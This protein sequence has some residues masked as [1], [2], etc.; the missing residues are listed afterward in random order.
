MGCKKITY[1]NFSILEIVPQKNATAK[2]IFRINGDHLGNVRLSYSDGNLD[3]TISQDE[4]IEESNYYPFGLK[5]KGYNYVQ[6]G[7]NDLA[8]NWKFNG[9]EQN[10]ELGLEWYDYGARNYDAA[11]GRWMNIDPLAETSRRFS[12]YTY[13]L[14]NP[15]YFIDPDGMQADVSAAAGSSSGGGGS[16]GQAMM[17]NGTITEGMV[18]NSAFGRSNIQTKNFGTSGET[19]GGC[20]KPP[21]NPQK[22]DDPITASTEN[23]NNKGGSF[24]TATIVIDDSVPK[25][26]F[27]DIAII[28]EDPAAGETEQVPF[29]PTKPG[30]YDNVDGVFLRDQDEDNSWYK[31]SDGA[32]ATISWKRK[33]GLYIENT[34]NPFNP[35]AL[36]PLSVKYF[37]GWVKKNDKNRIAPTKNPFKSN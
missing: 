32:K 23:N 8:Q 9:M 15:I 34:T 27:E 36:P 13:A 2:F 16:M 26:S 17:G 19:G 29:N 10:Q 14:N 4:I 24:P 5:H 30:E 11:L 35:F 37:V 6:Q 22:S 33:K 7:G 31:I 20:E 18:D 28:P 3:G 12:T 25:E 21:C 1:R